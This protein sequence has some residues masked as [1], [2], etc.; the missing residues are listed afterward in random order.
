[1]VSYP[2]IGF[3]KVDTASYLD[4]TSDNFKG[5]LNDKWL[6]RYVVMVM[7]V[8]YGLDDLIGLALGE[9]PLL[10]TELG[11]TLAPMQGSKLTLLYLV[12]EHLFKTVVVSIAPAHVHLALDLHAIDVAVFELL[13]AVK[14]F[15]YSRITQV[16]VLTVYG[17]GHPVRLL[18]FRAVGC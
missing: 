15:T 9:V 14:V 16:K 8:S 6:M 7:V 1:M 4:P 11:K 12:L 13:W 2:T 17:D 18:G 3:Y 5:F 10:P